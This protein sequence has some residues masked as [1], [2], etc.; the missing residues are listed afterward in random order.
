MTTN[1]RVL[2]NMT[3][4][5]CRAEYT[6]PLSVALWDCP[7]LGKAGYTTRCL[8]SED[9]EIED[10][11]GDDNDNDNDNNDEGEDETMAYEE[12][13]NGGADPE[14]LSFWSLGCTNTFVT[15]ST[16]ILLLLV[17]ASLLANH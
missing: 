3:R 2:Y 15:G 4:A 16:Q 8:L 12:E 14:D 6:E 5:L 13:D 7:G 1:C 9:N 11:S 10:E 17:E